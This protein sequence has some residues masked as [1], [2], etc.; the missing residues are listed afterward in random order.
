M[1]HRWGVDT[2][3]D[4]LREVPQRTGH[5]RALRR[6]FPWISSHRQLQRA[7]WIRRIVQCKL[8]DVFEAVMG[9]SGDHVRE[10][11]WVDHV[12]VEGGEYGRMVLSSRAKVRLDSEQSYLAHI[13]EYLQLTNVLCFGGANRS[14]FI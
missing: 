2:R 8:Q 10:G 14:S 3:H 6:I 9:S 7:N 1:D 11:E 4:G 5:R 13:P 12:D